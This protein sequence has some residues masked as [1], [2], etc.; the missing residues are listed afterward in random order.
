MRDRDRE[1]DVL[2]R[3]EAAREQLTHLDTAL[4]PQ[5]H[6]LRILVEQDFPK[7]IKELERVRTEPMP[8]GRDSD[9]EP[10]NGPSLQ[11]S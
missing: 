9:S 3:W 2:A 1:D 6:A 11:Y 10:Q 4:V 7:L 5:Q 8:R